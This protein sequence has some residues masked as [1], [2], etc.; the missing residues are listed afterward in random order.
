MLPNEDQTNDRPVS[1]QDLSDEDFFS[2]PVDT[3]HL[4]PYLTESEL[5]QNAAYEWC[6][7]DPEVQRQYAKQV[8]AASDGRILGAGKTHG[9]ALRAAL[10]SPGCPPQ[11]EIALVYIEGYPLPPKP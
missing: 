5:R 9:Q 3:S 1:D 7:R 2:P 8:V 10:Q 4:S 11:E 6:L